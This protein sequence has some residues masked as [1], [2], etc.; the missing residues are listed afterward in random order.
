MNVI[1]RQTS[2]QATF[3]GR[4]PS[5]HM[6]ISNTRG[7]GWSLRA[8][9]TRRTP[10]DSTKNISIGRRIACSRKVRICV[11]VGCRHQWCGNELHSYGGKR[12]D[13]NVTVDQRRAPLDIIL[14]YRTYQITEYHIGIRP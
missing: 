3:D 6:D 4:W 9:F 12:D 1:K 13:G 8:L 14:N 10:S 5:P 7:G 2:R 11:V